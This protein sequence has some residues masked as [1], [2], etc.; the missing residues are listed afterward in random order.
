MQDNIRREILGRLQFIMHVQSINAHTF[1][2]IIHMMVKYKIENA[3]KVIIFPQVTSDFSLS[4]H[5][6]DTHTFS[7][8]IQ[9]D[10]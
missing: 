4:P 6:P 1:K 2:M 7:Q 8:I 9:S 3:I 5:I 10:V